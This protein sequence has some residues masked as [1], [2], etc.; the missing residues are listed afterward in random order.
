MMTIPARGQMLDTALAVTPV[1]A[2]ALRAR[3]IKSIW[4]GAGWYVPEL[5]RTRA[6]DDDVAGLVGRTPQTATWLEWKWATGEPSGIF[7]RALYITF[8]GSTRLMI[9]HAG[10][11]GGFFPATVS[12]GVVELIRRLAAEGVDLVLLCMPM[13]G[14][15]FLY[16]TWANIPFVN[17]DG[18]YHNAHDDFGSRPDLQPPDG[19]GLQYFIAPIIGALDYVLALRAYDRQSAS[20]L[21]GGAW[22]ATVTAAI[23]PRITHLYAVAGSIPMAYRFDNPVILGDWEQLL[24]GI[25]PGLDYHDLYLMTVAEAGRRAIF[26]HTVTDSCCFD[27]TLVKTFAPELEWYAEQAGFSSLSFVYAEGVYGHDI[28]PVHQDKILA[29]FAAP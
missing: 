9:H 6:A 1:Q 15:N 19:S 7:A 10:H 17:L 13:D 26:L 28:F 12:P 3:I 5:T 11:G 22:A 29:D 2:I 27:G 4:G 18:S 21:S 20:G 24:V 25:Y 16:R 23:D 8:P 14:D